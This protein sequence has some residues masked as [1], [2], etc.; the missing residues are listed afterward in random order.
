M[1]M[2]R[3]PIVDRKVRL[4]LA[5]CGRVASNHFAAIRQHAARCELVDV[6]DTDAHRL[7]EAVAKTGARGH[8]DFTEMLG[9]TQADCIV[10]ATPSGLHP[11]QTIE[12]ARAGFDVVTEKPMATRW[13]DGLEMVRVCD[14]AG[15]RL[16]GQPDLLHS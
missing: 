8:N 2:R 7:A 16:F 1:P 6:C 15:V 5:G 4:A 12:A 9:A 13:H 10:L 11:I 3:P 14:A